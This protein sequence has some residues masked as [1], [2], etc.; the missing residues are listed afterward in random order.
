[1]T[2]LLEERC[3]LWLHERR[4][5][6]RLNMK[7]RLFGKVGH[8]CWEWQRSSAPSGELLALDIPVWRLH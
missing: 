1:M 4:W 7:A 2:N 8:V 3:T 6:G 5:A